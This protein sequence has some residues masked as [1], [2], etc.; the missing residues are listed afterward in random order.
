MEKRLGV[1]AVLVTQKKC[2]PVINSL[3]SE[4]SDIIYARQGLPMHNR[5]ISVIS[6]IVEGDTDRIGALTGKIGRCE[7]AEVKSI[8]TAYKEKDND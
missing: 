8:L 4:F 3:L 1:I 5:D 7:G 2:V 6:L